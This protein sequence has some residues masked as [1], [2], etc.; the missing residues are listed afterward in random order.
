[1][2]RSSD[3]IHLLAGPYALDALE[4]DERARFEQHLGGCDTCR[5]DLEGFREATEVL[6][7]ATSE[8]APPSLRARV[9]DEV[10][11]TRQVSPLGRTGARRWR[12]APALLVAAAAVLVAVVCGALLVD[13][14]RDIDR[15]EQEAA[16]ATLAEAPD[17]ASVDLAGGPGATWFTYAASQGR[18]VLV[19]EGLGPAPADHTYQLWVISGGIP[20]PAGVFD[21]DAQ[22][23]ASLEVPR[24]PGPGDRL[25]VTIEP[26]GG[27]DSPTTSP[28]SASE[29]V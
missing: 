11:R 25:A 18:G 3:D 16:L 4:D 2:S 26:A 12:T 23:H 13:A 19:S 10:G 27:S 24:A 7:L 8:P 22:G 21:P 15:L 9:L 5:H 28:I 14:R 1:M 6:A 29:P 20:D 17:L